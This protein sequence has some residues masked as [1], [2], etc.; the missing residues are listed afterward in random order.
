MLKSPLSAGVIVV[1][2]RRLSAVR[3]C[4]LCIQQLEGVMQCH[5]LFFNSLFL[6]P[7]ALNLL[8]LNWRLKPTEGHLVNTGLSMSIPGIGDVATVP[9]G[10]RGKSK[11][12]ARTLKHGN[13]KSKS[14]DDM[15]CKPTD[16]MK[17]KLPCVYTSIGLSCTIQHA[18]MLFQ[19]GQ[20]VSDN[21]VIVITM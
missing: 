14:P 11:T 13:V 18:S 8:G 5:V 17:S 21:S 20:K 1:G 15:K 7:I 12:R 19:C 6:S 10:G 4:H 3:T 16:S 9:S 2:C